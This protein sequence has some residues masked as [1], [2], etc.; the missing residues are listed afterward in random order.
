MCR[1]G[2]SWWNGVAMVVFVEELMGWW[3]QESSWCGRIVTLFIFC[4]H[5]NWYIFHE[6]LQCSSAIVKLVLGESFSFDEQTYRMQG[7]SAYE[8][9]CGK[10]N[11]LVMGFK[12]LYCRWWIH[13]GLYFRNKPY[14]K[15]WPA[16]RCVQ[17]MHVCF[18]C[19]SIYETM[20]IMDTLVFF[21]FNEPCLGNW[22]YGV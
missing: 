6:S 5:R 7:K 20:G 12:V 13:K 9:N 1:G 10:F 3:Q 2:Q 19:S 18:L 15:K 21:N 4:S 11:S 22:L 17:C 14:D 16:Q 8:T